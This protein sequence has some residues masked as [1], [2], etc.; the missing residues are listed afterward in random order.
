MFARRSKAVMESFVTP[1][2]PIQ[3]LI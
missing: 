2:C 1:R 3:A